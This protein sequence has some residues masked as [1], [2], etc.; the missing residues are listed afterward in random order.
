ME[1]I[2]IENR[3]KNIYSVLSICFISNPNILRKPEGGSGDSNTVSINCPVLLT[4][5][6]V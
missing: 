5:S 2:I 4:R 3:G 6:S 1:Y